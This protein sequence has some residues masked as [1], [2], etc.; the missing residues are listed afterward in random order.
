MSPRYTWLWVTLAAGLLGFIVLVERHWQPPKPRP[1]MVLPDLATAAV[2]AVQVRPAGLLEIRAER[3]NG[4]WRLVR[5][6]QYPAE[7]ER[8][9]GLVGALAGLQAQTFIAGA[10]LRQLTNA[11]AAFGFDVP[12]A[13]VSLQLGNQRRQVLVGSRTAPGD[14]V[15]VQVVGAEGVYVAS[16]E[17]LN[18]L[19]RQADDWRQ[20]ALAPMAGLTFDRIL[21]TNANAGFE[22]RRDGPAARWRLAEPLQARADP[23]RVAEALQALEQ[24]RVARFVTDDPAADLESYGLQPPALAICL[25]LGT[26]PVL[27]LHFGRNP[28]NEPERV[29]ARRLDV[30]GVVAVSARPLASWR[31]AHGE[32]RD[33]HLL[34]PDRPPDTVEVLGSEVFTLQR[35]G[36]DWR[37]LPLDLPADPDLVGALLTH[38][39]NLTVVE[40]VKDVVIDPDLARYGLAVPVR[41]FVLRALPEPSGDTNLLLGHVQFG[42]TVED[43][44]YARRPD[45]TSVYAVKSAE[46]EPLPAAPF[47]LRDRRIWNVDL[48]RVARVTI[49]EA[50]R[51]RQLVRQG[52][53]SWTL[54]AGST[55]LINPLAV[56]EAVEQLVRL[57]ALQWMAVGE[58]HLERFGIRPESWR[59]TLELSTGDRLSVQFGGTSPSQLVYA[60]T[61]LEGQV[62][63]FECP[64]A[65]SELARLALALP[66]DAP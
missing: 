13:S 37:I 49:Q 30:P 38:L 24:L 50:G 5:P 20:T 8:V 33:R 40:F 9:Q 22:L 56:E 11:D 64:P 58:A 2:T 62:W 34:S 16:A 7:S 44:T 43:K 12:Q 32:F 66:A 21:V 59:I 23:A 19:P 46:F 55:G 26:N 54:A 47:Q 1:Q 39:T 41:E 18:H 51:Q 36:R 53:H 28:T 35:F 61:L 45:E 29:F 27:Q 6:L 42:A 52:P 48:A 63:I 15:Y 57:Y 17:W 60:A 14:Q 4:L 65:V 10:E 31:A 25:A 3:S